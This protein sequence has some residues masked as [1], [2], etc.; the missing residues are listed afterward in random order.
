MPVGV[1]AVSRV[2]FT[3]AAAHVSGETDVQSFRVVDTPEHVDVVHTSK[4]TWNAYFITSFV[5]EGK[6]RVLPLPSSL[7]AEL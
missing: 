2:V 4:D 3:E 7:L 1:H 6:E 5:L